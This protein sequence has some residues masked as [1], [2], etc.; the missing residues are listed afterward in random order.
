MPELAAQPVFDSPFVFRRR[1]VAIDPDL[2]PL[3][4][5]A[6]LLCV[7]DAC[8]GGVANLEQLHVLDWAIRSDSSRQVLLEYLT[9]ERTAE[10]SIVRFDPTLDRAVCLAVGAGLLSSTQRST[11]TA[12]VP[13]Y[14]L[15]LTE[16]GERALRE[17]N[18][19]DF[20]VERSF[21]SA[22][23]RKLAQTDVRDLFT[24]GA[25]S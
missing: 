2:R 8:R 5:V 23:P 17:L 11:D 13:D 12:S 19:E 16:A 20:Q 3:R 18:P 1:P 7:V 15:Q 24:W 6:I 4:R 22:L 21:L 9:G 14:R 10:D 25:R